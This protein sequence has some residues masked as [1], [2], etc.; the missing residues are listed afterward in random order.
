VAAPGYYRDLWRSEAMTARRS[1]W[2]ARR[3]HLGREAARPGYARWHP[4]PFVV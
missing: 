1:G 4:A 2:P 3:G